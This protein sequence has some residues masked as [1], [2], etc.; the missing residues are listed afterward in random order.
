MT[1][2]DRI[3]ACRLRWPALTE[4]EYRLALDIR[5]LSE[6]GYSWN[7]IGYVTRIGAKKAERLVRRLNREEGE[8]A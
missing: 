1:V 6:A 8:T 2:C 5:A 4:K 3:E 7:T